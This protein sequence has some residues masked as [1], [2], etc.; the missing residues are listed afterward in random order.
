MN[1]IEPE[2]CGQRRTTEA[3]SSCLTP[4]GKGVEPSQPSAGGRNR[5]GCCIGEQQG[6]IKSGG[7]HGGGLA[8]SRGRPFPFHSASF[9]SLVSVDL[10]VVFVM[11]M[12]AKLNYQKSETLFSVLCCLLSFLAFQVCRRSTETYRLE[13]FGIQKDRH[14]SICGVPHPFL[15]NLVLWVT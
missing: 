4:S 7:F 8:G 14:L 9:F 15:Y 10:N 12:K 2:E 11:L 3:P 5:T 13:M 6:F 1:D